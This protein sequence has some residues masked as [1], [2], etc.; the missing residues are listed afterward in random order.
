MAIKT[1]S[2]IPGIDIHALVLHERIAGITVWLIFFLG[3]ASFIIL[4]K[5]RRNVFK[6]Y[7]SWHYTI[8]IASL[9]IFIAVAFT[10]YYGGSIR[11]TE[12][13]G[14]SP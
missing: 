6:N 9:I 4:N 14:S 7:V 13:H 11:H 5:S 10:G 3:V 8:L 12:I 1:V 2:G